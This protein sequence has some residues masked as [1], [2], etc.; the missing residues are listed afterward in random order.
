IYNIISVKCFAGAQN[1][2]QTEPDKKLKKVITHALDTLTDLALDVLVE[3]TD[4]QLDRVVNEYFNG[5]CESLKS[6]FQRL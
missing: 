5:S 6:L 3:M 2:A 1:A 4:E